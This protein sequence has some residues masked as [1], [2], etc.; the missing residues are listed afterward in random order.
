[1]L[2]GLE[3]IC[4]AIPFST[5]TEPISARSSSTGPM[6]CSQRTWLSCLMCTQ[7]WITWLATILSYFLARENPRKS[8]NNPGGSGGGSGG[9]P[10]VVN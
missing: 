8:S 10:I 2:T 7:W 6:G 4:T 9:Q 1:M 5:D 3:V